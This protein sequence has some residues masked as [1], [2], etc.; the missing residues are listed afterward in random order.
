MLV[1]IAFSASTPVVTAGRALSCLGLPDKL[2]H[3]LFFTVRYIQVIEGEYLRMRAA[4]VV[5]GF[6]PGTSFHTYRSCAYMVGMLLVRSSDRAERVYRAMLC[7]G[8]DGRFNRLDDFAMS[9]KDWGLL[10]VISL[11]LLGIG[12]LE[13]MVTVQ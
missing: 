6:K 11:W 4:M 2:V 8:F 9:G 12:W 5:R 3:L 1:F 7:R 10:L 13:W